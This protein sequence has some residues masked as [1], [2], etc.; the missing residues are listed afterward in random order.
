MFPFYGVW[1]NLVAFVIGLVL[2]LWT[3]K[4]LDKLRQDF[5]DNGTDHDWNKEPF[6]W[7]LKAVKAALPTI[8][9]IVTLIFMPVRFDT[10]NVGEETVNNFD[11][12]AEETIQIERHEVKKYQPKNNE[13]EY[14]QFIKNTETKES[15]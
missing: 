2:L 13:G 8:V 1:F 10:L 5:R 15:K 3:I 11:V 12:P 7:P 6:H 14:E 4:R 9:L